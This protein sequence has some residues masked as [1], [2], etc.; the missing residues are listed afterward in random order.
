[1]TDVT[2]DWVAGL[3]KVELHVHVEGAILP[4]T[5]MRLAQKNHVDLPPKTLAEF[6]DWYRFTDFPHFAEV[7]W[8]F[9]K[10]IQSEEDIYQVALAFL[11]TQARQK[12][13]HT[14][15]TFTAL[16]HFKNNGTAFADQI[17]AIRKALDE[18][19]ATEDISLGLIIDIPRDYATPEE[20]MMVAEWVTRH[21]GDGL[22]AALGLG[23]Y[24]PGF[25]PEDFARPFALAK[26]AGV[27]AVTHAG[28][29]GTAASIRV[30]VEQLGAVRIGHGVAAAGDSNVLAFLKERQIPLEVCPSSN[31]CLK[32]FDAIANHP[33][34]RMDEYGLN[35]SLNTDDPPMFDTDLNREY[36]RVAQTFGYSKAEMKGF[37]VRAAR[38]ALLPEAKRETL[39]AEIAAYAD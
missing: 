26:E 39:A 23:G 13:R 22:I 12:V 6:R 34:R 8:A 17:A 35:I 20:S 31:V 36:L 18:V 37:A 14:E 25:P 15:A 5:L 3:P 10:A 4:E 19:R 1:M 2:E 32:V 33:F 29:T 30:A 24:E 7:Y 38:A 9:S 28:E 27:P 16:T 21:H 11:K